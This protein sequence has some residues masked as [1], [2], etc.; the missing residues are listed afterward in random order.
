MSFTKILIANRGEIAVRIHRTAHALG[1]RTVAVFSDADRGAL[2]AEVADEAV[3]IGP[4]PP[5]ESYLR[6][7]KIVGAARRTGAEAVHPGYGFLAE[8]PE[9]AR[10]CADAG[11][12]FIGPSVEAMEIMGDKARARAQARDV[13]VPCIP[14]HEGE[15]QSA[16]AFARAAEEIGYPLMIK[17]VAGGGGRGLRRVDSA[18]ELAPSLERAR[19]EAAGAFGDGDLLLER[20]V[21][22]ARHVEVQVFGDRAGNVIHLGERDCSLQRRHQKIIEECPSPAVGEVL[23]EEM[24]TAAVR[25]AE[26]VGYV[27]AGTVEF[28]LDRD[29]RFYFLEMNTR[30]QVEHP[31]TEMV[32]GLDLVEWQLRIAAGEP[33]PIAQSAVRLA[34]HAIEARLYAEDPG[35]GFLPQAGEVRW[36]QPPASR[37]GVRVDAGIRTG[38]IV[39]PFYDP[40]VAKVVARGE[41]RDQARRRLIGALEECVLFGPRHNRSFL[42]ALLEDP[43][44]VAGDADTGFVDAL[45]PIEDPSPAPWT[46]AVAAVRIS[47]RG[48]R[49]GDPLWGF[50]NTEAAGWPLDL[51]CDDAGDAVEARLEPAGEGYRVTVD[52]RTLEVEQVVPAGARG[53]APRESVR[54]RCDGI[55]RQVHVFDDGHRLDLDDGRNVHVFTEAVAVGSAEETD[56]GTVTAPMAARVVE[57]HAAAGDRVEAGQCLLVLEA[58]KLQSRVEA[59]RAGRVAELRVAVDDQV[60]FRQVLA[61]LE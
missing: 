8:N 48:R 13:G 29:G 61:V 55:E 40:L 58:M 1:Y 45:P 52:G 9:L 25:L 47:E 42:I 30:L 16:E 14:G 57:V 7:D 33:L 3:A 24:G 23:R 20:Y 53:R 12:A 59:R 26:S 35:R 39:P 49:D 37:P 31:V 11:L 50:R 10:A 19:S 22:R 44:F 34:G 32:T 28:L 51:T 43:A 15:D 54:F 41:S 18:S 17:A 6:I 2:H 46:V 38:S 5:A 27:G 56:D 60:V 36:F 21:E 4:A